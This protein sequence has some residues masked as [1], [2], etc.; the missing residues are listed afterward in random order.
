MTVARVWTRTVSVLSRPVVRRLLVIV[1]LAVGGWLLGGLSAAHA[2]EPRLPSNPVLD[3]AVRAATTAP[4]AGKGLPQKL[5]R[6]VPEEKKAETLPAAAP[7]VEPTGRASGT[8]RKAM[9]A[10]KG[11]PAPS[12]SVHRGR[13]ATARRMAVVPKRA[14]AEHRPVVQ[15]EQPQAPEQPRQVLL[16]STAQAGGLIVPILLAGVPGR[17]FWTAGLQRSVLTADPGAVPPLV[18]TAADEPSFAPD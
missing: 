8:A 15:D 16:P 6:S 9:R 17:R 3:R 14:T 10:D 18:R 5:V 12:R 4:I 11:S 2:D 13:K 1:G 7:S